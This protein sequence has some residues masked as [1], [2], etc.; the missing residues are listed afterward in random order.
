M[1]QRERWQVVVYVA[2]AYRGANL[3]A[4]QQNIDRARDLAGA[5]WAAGFTVLCPHLNA[6]LCLSD[7]IPDEEWL[8]RDLE[9]MARCDAVVVVPKSEESVGTV[10]E[11]REAG[12]VDMP[13]FFLLEALLEAF[14]AGEF[15]WGG[16][17]QLTMDN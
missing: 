10:G 16:F 15:T 6:P 7:L 13:V 12:S 1:E 4:V 3:L 2:G 8:R 17:G 14:E 5:L 9:M 11:I